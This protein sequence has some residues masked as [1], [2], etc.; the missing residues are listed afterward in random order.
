MGAILLTYAGF[1]A[2]GIKG[3]SSVPDQA[4]I[5]VVDANTVECFQIAPE[6][7][8]PVLGAGT[9]DWGELIEH[10]NVNKW[11]NFGPYSFSFSGGNFVQ[12]LDLSAHYAVARFAGYNHDAVVP[13][14]VDKIT[15]RTFYPN[16]SQVDIGCTLNMGEID[17]KKAGARFVAIEVYESDGTTLVGRGTYDLNTA[18]YG[19]QNIYFQYLVDVSSHSSSFQL[20]ARI[21]FLDASYNFLS[22][23]PGETAMYSVSMNYVGEPTLAFSLAPNSP[24]Y[25]YDL[26]TTGSSIVVQSNTLNV[27]V[28]IDTNGDGG[29]DQTTP[30]MYL[31]KGSTYWYYDNSTGNW[32]S[33]DGNSTTEPPATAKITTFTGTAYKNI[34]KTLPFSIQYGD[35]IEVIFGNVPR[36]I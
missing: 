35:A 33:W 20:K 1:S 24:W 7:V 21:C 10:P 12:T 8:A 31:R 29:F 26:Y 32:V 13:S 5:N 34:S 25:N 28:G 22:Y 23:F 14:V 16:S 2:S 9:T 19:D 4:Y 3:R 15:S 18:D 27:Y 6:Q 30:F 11:S 36:P 17:W